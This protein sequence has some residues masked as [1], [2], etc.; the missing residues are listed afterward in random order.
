MMGVG[1]VPLMESLASEDLVVKGGLQW[2]GLIPEFIGAA[3][4]AMGQPFP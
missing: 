4:A 1:L 2:K 3:I